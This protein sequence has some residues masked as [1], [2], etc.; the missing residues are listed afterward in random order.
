MPKTV[1]MTLKN[2]DTIQTE[3][4]DLKY[5][6]VFINLAWDGFLT[7][8][9]PLE[10]LQ[11]IHDEKEIHDENLSFAWIKEVGEILRIRP[12]LEP[13]S[14]HVKADEILAQEAS[15]R[16]EYRKWLIAPQFTLKTRRGVMTETENGFETLEE[17]HE[18]LKTELRNH[19]G[20]ETP[21]GTIERMI[22]DNILI[23]AETGYSTF[24][25]GARFFHIEKKADWANNSN[26][27]R[28]APAPTAPAP[29]RVFFFE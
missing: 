24:Q 15:Q 9:P 17:L 2:R 8:P 22:E 25:G 3:Y 29:T 7:T 20:S 26:A 18:K 13:S 1:P 16:E 27:I 4:K 5:L 12:Q 28:V 10:T 14:L 23:M 19:M 11:K 21:D 6:H